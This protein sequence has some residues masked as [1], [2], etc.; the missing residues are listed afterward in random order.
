MFFS[1]SLG[2][3]VDLFSQSSL[4]VVFVVVR[5][6][7]GGGEWVDGICDV[8]TPNTYSVRTAGPSETCGL[9]GRLA[10]IDRLET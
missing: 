8:T 2:F 6:R 7:S 9:L 10:V 4:W 3:K 1:P 5:C